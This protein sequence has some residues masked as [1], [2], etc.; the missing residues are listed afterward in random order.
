MAVYAVEITFF[1][2]KFPFESIIL[3]ED[4]IILF[5]LIS[6][7]QKFTGTFFPRIFHNQVIEFDETEKVAYPPHLVILSSKSIDPNAESA[8]I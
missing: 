2:P 4:A 1:C 7:L 6:A 5:S 3:V 8:T